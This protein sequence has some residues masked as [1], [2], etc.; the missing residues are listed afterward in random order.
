[1]SD[2]QLVRDGVTLVGYDTGEGP[3]VLFQHG[4]GGDDAQV[5][6]VFP[7]QGFRRLTLECRAQGRSGAGDPALFSIPIFADD[8]LA[9][10]DQRGLDRFVIGG[11]STGAAIALRI[12][13]IAPHRV[14]ALIL[15]RPAWLWTSAPQNMH[16]FVEL[17]DYLEA[18]DK[19]G[20]ANTPTA[21]HY[22]VHAPDNLASMI[23]FFQKTNPQTNASL[24]RAIAA[25]GPEITAQDVRNITAPTLV[26]GTGMDLVHPLSHAQ[27]LAAAIPNARLAEIAAKALDRA[28]HAGEF[29]A[30]VADFLNTEGH[31]R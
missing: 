18:G 8:V 13:V 11:I 14:T 3:P 4:L 22:A 23:G 1:M 2:R 9:F 21:R 20:F 17:A 5:A 24:L 26:L 25:S 28:K 12:A 19:E 29:R 16:A 7:A 6:E 10:A 27:S 15:A 30:T 31:L